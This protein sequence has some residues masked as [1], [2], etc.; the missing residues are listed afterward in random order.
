M[1]E[2]LKGFPDNVVAVSCKGRVTKGDYDNV[3]VPTV[4]KAL[5]MHDKMRLYYEAGPE[6]GGIDPSAAWEDF[7][8]GMEHFRRWQ[9]V[10]LVTDVDWIKRTM[11][12]FGFIMPGDMRVFPVAEAAQARAWI[13]SV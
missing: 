13:K 3:L 7:K 4:D 2:L 1:I 5:K 11:Q 6:F 8:I 10:A 12:I 9:R